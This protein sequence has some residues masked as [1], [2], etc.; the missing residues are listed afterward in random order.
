MTEI[1]YFLMSHITDKLFVECKSSRNNE[2][3]ECIGGL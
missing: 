3:D 2:I 1:K